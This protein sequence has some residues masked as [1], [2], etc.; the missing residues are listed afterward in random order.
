[1]IK[2]KTAA[3]ICNYKLMPERIGGMDYFFIQ[4]DRNIKMKGFNIDWYFS[5]INYFDFYKGLNLFDAKCGSVENF[6]INTVVLENKHY[7]FIYTHFTELCSFYYKKFK[8]ILPNVKI[9]AVDHNPR[10]L[11]G[12]AFNKRIKNIIKS[13]LYLKYIDKIIAVSNYSKNNLINDFTIF[14]I[15]KVKIILNGIRIKNYKIKNNYSTNFN[16]I[17]ASHLREE[18]GVQDIIEA[19]SLLRNEY[20]KTIKLT[21]FGEGVYKYKLEEKVIH[22]GLQ[23]QIKF[24]GSVA[25][26]NLRYATYDY[27]LHASYGETFCFS[28]VE[29]LFSKLPVVTTSKVGNVLGLVKQDKNGFLFNVGDVYGLSKILNDILAFNIEI[30]K[31]SFDSIII[32]DLSIDRMVNEYTELI[33]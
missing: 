18:K 21:I 12:F 33:K 6:F 22:F 2:T 26:I 16:F 1:M 28:V 32:P 3:V 20:K 5:D 25:D 30:N 24:M 19:I 31:K 9:Y 14:I 23:K 15:P 29:S 8:K 11:N 10:P 7:D 27:L 13:F 4:F 17:V